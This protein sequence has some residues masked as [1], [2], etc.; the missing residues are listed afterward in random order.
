MIIL[1]TALAGT[2]VDG[3]RFSALP[4]DRVELDAKSEQNL[5]K[6]GL[7]TSAKTVKKAVKK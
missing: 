1:K 5:I 7:A 4:N 2:D 6:K 3:K